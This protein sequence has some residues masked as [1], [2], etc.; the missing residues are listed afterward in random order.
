MHIIGVDGGGTKTTV[1]LADEKGEIISQEVGG[2]SNWRNVGVTKSAEVVFSLIKKIKK[3]KQISLSYIALAGIEEEWKE[4]KD[5]FIKE[6]KEKGLEGEVILGSD[7]LAAFRAGT[8]E[9]EGV[10][11]ICG[12]GTVARGFKNGKDVKASAWGF[13]ADEGAAFYTGIEGYRAV[14]KAFDERGEKTKI[15]DIMRREW[16]VETPEELNK[17]VY[18]DFLKNIPLLS[19]MV[20]EAGREGD[21]IAIS[22]LERSGKEVALYAKTVIKKL[23][24]KEKFPVVLSG[25][26]FNSEIFLSVFKKEI[27]CFAPKAEII[28]LEEDPVKG[29][30]KLAR[31]AVRDNSSINP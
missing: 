5:D 26:M 22:I 7:Q 21:K 25:G 29:A 6:L 31:D 28:L 3:E 27:G 4:K 16:S 8:D 23:G 19:I 2:P 30:V 10:I 18:G 17:K 1:A 24:F 9:K 20:G 12:T 14:Q 15:A 13:L 11:V